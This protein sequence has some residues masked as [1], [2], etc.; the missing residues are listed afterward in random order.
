MFADLRSGRAYRVVAISKVNDG[1]GHT[2]KE[3]IQTSDA[4][5]IPEEQLM[6]LRDKHKYNAAPDW[7]Y[8]TLPNDVTSNDSM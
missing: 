1:F 8:L 6:A 2:P 3:M 5:P 7:P 4:K